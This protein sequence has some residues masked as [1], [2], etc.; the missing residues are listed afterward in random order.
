MSSRTFTT[1]EANKML[2]LV[3]SITDDIRENWDKIVVL[4][5]EM[6]CTFTKKNIESPSYM[7]EELNYLIDK[8]NRY[9]K[10]MDD[11]GLFVAEFKRGV[12]NFPSLRN[13]HKVFLS[14]MTGEGSVEFWHELDETSQ[15]R[16]HLNLQESV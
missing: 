14:W 11:L 4:R 2:P 13:G 5:T 7:K 3:R 10:E 15:N 9:I 8:V 1:T 6:E 16:K 12:I